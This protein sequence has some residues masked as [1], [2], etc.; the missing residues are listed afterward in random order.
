VRPWPQ[1]A[2][3]IPEPALTKGNFPQVRELGSETVHVSSGQ[4]LQRPIRIFV[5][6]AIKSEGKCP[7]RTEIKEAATHLTALLVPA[8][9]PGY[10]PSP[11]TG[12]VGTEELNASNCYRVGIVSLALLAGRTD[13]GEATVDDE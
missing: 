4:P 8:I 10:N 5:E 9:A 7:S 11:S 6:P 13:G 12:V 2:R 3:K 1:Q